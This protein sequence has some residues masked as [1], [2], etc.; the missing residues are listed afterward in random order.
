MSILPID[1]PVTRRAG[2]AVDYEQFVRRHTVR[3]RRQAL[4]RLNDLGDSEEIAQ[5]TLLRAHEHWH[6]FADEDAAAAW[7]SVVAGRLAVDRLRVR[8]RSVPVADVAEG[9]RVG[10]DTAEV[11]VAR[12]EARMA[13]E[14]LEAVP[15]R[16]AS[17]LW[18]RE[19]EGL[20][21]DQI[22]DRHGLSEPTVRSLLHRGRKALRREYAERGGTL[23]FGGVVVV[24]LSPALD[25][26]RSLGRLRRSAVAGAA[27][28][29]AALAIVAAV[30][31]SPPVAAPVTDLPS[32]APVVQQEVGPAPVPPPGS[33]S[34]APT[35]VDPPLPDPAPTPAAAPSVEPAPRAEP[36]ALDALP[37]G[38]VGTGLVG[39]CADRPDAAPEGGVT[40]DLPLPGDTDL[41]DELSSDLAGECAVVP[42]P[43]CRPSGEP[44]GPSEDPREPSASEPPTN[45]PDDSSLD[46]PDP[47][48]SQPDLSKDL[49]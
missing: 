38:C 6:E 49:R 27:A 16:Q 4:R 45:E 37:T 5:E 25:A 22:A 3:L 31:L 41:P 20:S 23:P 35:A 33:D 7:T 17:V 46:E 24:A 48:A 36:D 32:L 42:G 8:G 40:V 44:A 39:A 2:E 1:A 34:S 13:L 9:A 29:T 19:V 26:L 21:Y 14:A 43:L 15:N 47:S 11:V 12:A 18:A 30:V 10:R 28:T